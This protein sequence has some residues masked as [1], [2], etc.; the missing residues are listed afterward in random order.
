[1]ATQKIETGLIA[2]SAVTTAKL[3]DNS[4]T[5][6]KIAAGSLDDQVKGISSSADAVAITID[7]SENVG[8]GG[9][10]DTK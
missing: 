5:A 4:V 9:S 8:I 1:M 2:D 3:A 10:P 6:A 7:S